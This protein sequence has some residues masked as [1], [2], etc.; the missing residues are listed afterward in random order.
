LQGFPKTIL[1]GGGGKHTNKPADL[2][3]ANIY[4]KSSFRKLYPKKK[5]FND[6][7]L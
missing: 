7:K 4:N 1:K 2:K 6:Y 5:Y 3:I